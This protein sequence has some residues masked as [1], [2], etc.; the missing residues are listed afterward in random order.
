MDYTVYP[1]RFHLSHSSMLPQENHAHLAQEMV[2][3]SQG[4]RI[5]GADFWSG[6]F[7]V[8]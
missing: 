5:R 6:N 8:N 2:Q 1:D 7:S 4:C 3:T